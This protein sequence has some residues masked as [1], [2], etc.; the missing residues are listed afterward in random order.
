MMLSRTL[1]MIIFST[2]FACG[3]K[4]PKVVDETQLNPKVSVAHLNLKTDCAECHEAERLPPNVE[5]NA[6]EL[7][8]LGADCSSC[9]TWPAFKTI[10][11]SVK[12]HNPYPAKCLG[13]HTVASEMATHPKQG[14]CA[15]CH[16]WPV[17]KTIG[18]KK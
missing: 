8:G 4:Q 18:P 5:T 13:C 10:N 17:W 9:H 1:F 6:T 16:S 12:A 2:L 7:H 3:T 14:E 11:D 15:A